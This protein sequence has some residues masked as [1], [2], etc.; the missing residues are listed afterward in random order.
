MRA[1]HSFTLVLSLLTLVAQVAAAQVSDPLEAQ[2]IKSMQL[3]RKEHLRMEEPGV[4]IRAYINSGHVSAKPN[5]RQDYTDYRILKRPAR[6]FGQLIVVLEEEYL[7]RFV[8]CCVSPGIGAILQ[9]DAD[10][11]ALK[12]FA[13]SNGC[14]IDSSRNVVERL[15]QLGL[16][17]QAHSY[18]S[19][20]CRERDIPIH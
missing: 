19:L 2:L 11:A 12:N 15:R 16:K 4:A 17:P 18:V 8:G 6:L 10:Q 13:S 9:V 7:K 20:S 14:L 1:T 3:N 5:S